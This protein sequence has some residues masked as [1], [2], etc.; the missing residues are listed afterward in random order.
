MDLRGKGFGYNERIEAYPDGNE[1]QY[2]NSPSYTNNGAFGKS[3][4]N[5]A[6]TS[7][8]MGQIGADA[9]NEPLN[10]SGPQFTLPPP[11]RTFFGVVTSWTW[12]LLSCL[13][14]IGALIGILVVLKQF[15]GKS[16]QDWPY[17]FTINTLVSILV[18]IIK[19][20]IVVPLAEGISQLKWS[21]YKRRE[22]ALADMVVFDSASRGIFG[23]SRLLFTR[24][25]L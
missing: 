23:A 1:F 17:H 12:E 9:W 24:N 15:N 19:V 8:R 25:P 2:L 18:T 3:N 16:L 11:R 13:L 10:N 22:N 4:E 21:W 7:F 20:A 14:A 5:S 6:A